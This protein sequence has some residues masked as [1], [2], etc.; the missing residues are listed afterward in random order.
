MNA[1]YKQ[2]S[3]QKHSSA[4]QKDRLFQRFIA[5]L[6]RPTNTECEVRAYAEQLLVTPKKLRKPRYCDLHG[7]LCCKSVIF[8]ENIKTDDH[9]NQKTHS[10]GFFENLN[11]F[12]VVLRFNRLGAR[13]APY[14][15]LDA[16]LSLQSALSQRPS[17]W[18]LL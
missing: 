14:F 18:Q 2:N 3:F 13:T 1:A 6:S 11:H 7:W 17:E 4:L 8:A 12:V 15:A 9:E 16:G 10:S 5:L